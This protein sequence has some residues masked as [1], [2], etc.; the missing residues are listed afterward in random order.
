MPQCMDD[1][2]RDRLWSVLKSNYPSLLSSNFLISIDL[3]VFRVVTI[4]NP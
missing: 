2:I 3:T 1:T 4:S